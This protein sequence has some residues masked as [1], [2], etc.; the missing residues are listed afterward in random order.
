MPDKRDRI[1]EGCVPRRIEKGYQPRRE[2]DQGNP[3]GGYQPERQSS[4]ANDPTP[5]GDE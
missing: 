1:D 4:E 2:S 3:Q 5:P